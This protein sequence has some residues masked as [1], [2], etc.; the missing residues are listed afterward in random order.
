MQWQGE[1][2]PRLAVSGPAFEEP[3]PTAAMHVGQRV[4][5]KDKQKQWGIKPQPP[6]RPGASAP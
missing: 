2:Q 4:P 1:M 5:A 6:R 3:I